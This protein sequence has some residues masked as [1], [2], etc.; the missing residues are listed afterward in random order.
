MYSRFAIRLGLVLREGAGRAVWPV[1]SRS[2]GRRHVD[3]DASG[4]R[5]VPN[6]RGTSRPRGDCHIRLAGLVDAYTHF[7]EDRRHVLLGLPGIIV[8]VGYR[9]G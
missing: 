2:V 4:P 8:R 7:V 5:P 9:L 3:L 6:R 1:P